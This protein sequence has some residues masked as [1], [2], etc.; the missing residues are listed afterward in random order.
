MNKKWITI[1]KIFMLYIFGCLIVSIIVESFG[2]E[3]LKSGLEFFLNNPYRAF[4]NTSLI[5]LFMS[6]AFLFKRRKFA[7]CI[8]ALPWIFISGASYILIH[9]RGSPLTK[10]DFAMISDSIT[11]A[12]QYISIQSLFLFLIILL[13]IIGGLVVLYRFE[14]KQRRYPM[15]FIIPILVV[16]FAGFPYY[17]SPLKQRAALLGQL[18]DLYSSY[19]YNGFAH[20]F[21]YTILNSGISKPSGYDKDSVLEVVNQYD[22]SVA[23]LSDQ[24]E[25]PNII[26]VQL[27]SFFDPT[28]VNDFT[29][30][31][32]PIPV[33]R[34]LSEEYSSGLLQVPVIGG[35]TVN[36]EFE[37]LT[38]FPILNFASGE[39]P[40]NSIV[41]TK[42]IPTINY[43]LKDYGYSTHAIHNHDGT[44]Y[45]RY[46][47]YSNLGFDTFTSSEYMYG[48]DKTPQ[49]WIKDKY[50][51]QEIEKIITS[52]ESKDVIYTVS[53]QGHGS[54]PSDVELED[55]KIF[56]TDGITGDMKNSWEYFIYQINEMDTFIGQLIEML[57][58]LNEPTVLV[59]FGDHLPG[60]QLKDDDLSTG[61]I[62]VTPYVIWDNIGLEERDIDITSYQL[63][64][65]VLES[66]KLDNNSLTKLHINHENLDSYLEN[67]NLLQYDILYGNN[68]SNYY[69]SIKASSLQLGIDPI[70]ITGFTKEGHKS[71]VVGEN[72]TPHSRVF[73]NNQP[74]ETYIID[75]HQLEFIKEDIKPGDFVEVKQVG[76]NNLILSS[77][78][79]VTFENWQ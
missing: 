8:L 45:D 1:L 55:Q 59:L 68:Y 61:T 64:S 72:F 21:L 52:T 27:E 67:L 74:C 4:Y 26:F 47:V 7:F 70:V 48:Y 73:V 60:L 30:N 22:V 2:Q 78:E 29:F 71:I 13:I 18:T 20:S 19:Q 63:A 53:V 3:S 31:E 23:E 44:F 51:T 32:D 28:W 11:L 33:F 42:P 50:L 39:I 6:L 56:I 46:L 43:I 16:L 25:T 12:N 36:T 17:I 24:E 37:V 54:Y 14:N 15:K 79:G 5:S 49:G 58:S 40:Y 75:D 10:S 34:A 35:G 62:Y 38:G 9:F 66:L 76:R 65:Y 57:L 77:T 69:T 41:K